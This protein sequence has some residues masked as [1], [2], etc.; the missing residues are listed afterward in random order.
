MKIRIE[1]VGGNRE[2]A[3]VSYLRYLGFSKEKQ[4]RFNGREVVFYR[5]KITFKTMNIAT[6][7]EK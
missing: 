7:N 2:G 6:V 4:I 5:L 1:N 3:T